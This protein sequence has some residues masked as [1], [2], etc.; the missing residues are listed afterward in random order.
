MRSLGRGRSRGRSRRST[1]GPARTAAQSRVARSRRDARA[2]AALVR[3][4]EAAKA[5]GEL[6]LAHRS[7]TLSKVATG[8]LTA[9]EAIARVDAVTRFE[10]L[11]R[12]A[13][14]SAAYLVGRG[15]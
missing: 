15:E 12:H 4:E 13:W 14:R 2:P 11:A 10:A 8:E 9:D 7:A 6:R 5:L 3:L 1:D